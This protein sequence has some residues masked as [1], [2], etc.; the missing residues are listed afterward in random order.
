M[1]IDLISAFP[2]YFAPLSLSLTGKAIDAGILEVH[3]HDLRDFAPGRHRSVDDAPFGG[4]PGMVMSAPVWGEALDAV[5]A[6]GVGSG[7][8]RPRLVVPTPSGRLF[9]QSLAAKY[10][11]EPWVIIACGRYEGIDAR[12]V[13]HYQESLAVDEVSLGDYVLAGGEAAALAVV[14]A[15][16]RLLPGVLGNEASAQDDSFSFGG[17][18]LLEGPVYTRPAVWRGLAVPAVLRSGDHAEIDRWRHREAIRRTRQMRPEL[19]E[20]AD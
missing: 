13:A 11:E 17:G 4:G 15:V 20:G 6:T 18:G 1:R 9:R 3:A 8:G 10:A 2:D 7:L 5:I 16:A 14:E 12:V 19:V